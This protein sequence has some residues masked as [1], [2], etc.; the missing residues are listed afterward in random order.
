MGAYFI[1][2]R[3][4]DSSQ[5]R[6]P[7]QLVLR[8]IQQCNVGARA[9]ISAISS[10]IKS[11][12]LISDA[13]WLGMIRKCY[14]KYTAETMDISGGQLLTPQRPWTWSTE[15]WYS[16][17]TLKS[18]NHT[19]PA[20]PILVVIIKA[21]LDSLMTR[22]GLNNVVA[23]TVR[24]KLICVIALCKSSRIQMCVFF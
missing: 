16:P 20:F 19:Q 23:V 4:A 1:E 14:C 9:F 24:D 5:S 15:A 7:I 8:L 18:S 3:R 6:H 21:K 10:A 17:L 12:S 13:R 2:S 22:E 11:H